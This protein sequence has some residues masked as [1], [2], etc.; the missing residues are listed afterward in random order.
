MLVHIR[1]DGNYPPTVL[2]MVDTFYGLYEFI[3]ASSRLP[4]S[5]GAWPKY[6]YKELVIRWFSFLN[7]FNFPGKSCAMSCLAQ[8]RA[9]QLIN[10]MDIYSKRNELERNKVKPANRVRSTTNVLRTYSIP[11]CREHHIH[12][13]I[14]VAR[15]TLHSIEFDPISSCFLS[16][17]FDQKASI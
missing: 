11:K 16:N 2:H 5:K 4:R 8:V 7:K 12:Q 3:V 13:F 17:Y 10:L 14:G 1:C 9:R 6:I 15:T